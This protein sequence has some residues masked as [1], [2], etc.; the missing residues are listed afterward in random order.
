MSSRA[1]AR[2]LLERSHGWL[3]VPHARS[4]A[5]AR[6]DNARDD[7]ARDAG[8]YPSAVVNAA[9]CSMS[10]GVSR[11][12]NRASTVP[13]RP[14]RNFVKFHLIAVVPSTPRAPDFRIA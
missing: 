12:P 1:A 6:D 7:N 11:D 5:V 4:L 2:D 13:S 14:T 10:S 8:V 3:R 9:S